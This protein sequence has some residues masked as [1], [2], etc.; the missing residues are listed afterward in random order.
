V[1]RP[2]LALPPI[3]GSVEENVNTHFP[4]VL[5]FVEKRAIGIVIFSQQAHGLPRRLDLTPISHGNY[6]QAPIKGLYDRLI[7]E[8]FRGIM[9]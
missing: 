2:R 6:G 7:H 5:E 8:K 4:Q 9:R 3:S 1:N